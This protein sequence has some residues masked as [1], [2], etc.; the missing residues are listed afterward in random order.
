MGSKSSINL[1]D[2]TTR[3][4]WVQN[5][6][7]IHESKKVSSKKRTKFWPRNGAATREQ[8]KKEECSALLKTQRIVKIG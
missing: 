3:F 8:R 5:E 1:R 7:H 6:N 4:I 2:K